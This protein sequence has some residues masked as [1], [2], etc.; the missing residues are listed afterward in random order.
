ML[1]VLVLFPQVEETVVEL[2]QLEQGTVKLECKLNAN[3]IN[4]INF[5]LPATTIDTEF[6]NPRGLAHV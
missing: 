3:D 6:V 2:A 5:K 1:V 4:K